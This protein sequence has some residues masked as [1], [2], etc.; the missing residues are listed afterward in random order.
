M[1]LRVTNDGLDLYPDLTAA[2]EQMA[3]M[4]RNDEKQLFDLLGLEGEL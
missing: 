4:L 3:E 2:F 1:E